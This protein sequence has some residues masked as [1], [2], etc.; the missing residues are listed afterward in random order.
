MFARSRDARRGSARVR[1]AKGCNHTWEARGFLRAIDNRFFEMEP[2][3]QCGP[4]GLRQGYYC[5]GLLYRPLKAGNEVLLW[6]EWLTHAATVASLHL[7]YGYPCDDIA[8]DVDAFDILVYSRSN[9]SLIAV[10]AKKTEKELDA[11]L[12]VMKALELTGLEVKCNQPRL[13][14]AAK[15]FRSLRAIRPEFFLAAAPGVERHYELRHR[16][17]GTPKT[18]ELIPIERIPPFAAQSSL[19]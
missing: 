18:A 4:V 7:D 14:N 16:V 19:A 1:A 6:R 5:Y 12:A 2:D 15:K 9:Q 3:G 17:D 10:E 13:S 11:M 8:L